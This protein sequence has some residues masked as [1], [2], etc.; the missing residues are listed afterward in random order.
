MRSLVS[1]LAAGAAALAMGCAAAPTNFYLLSPVSGPVAGARNPIVVAVGPVSLPDYLDR[2]QIVIR[3]GANAAVL[4][5][6][7]QWAGPLDDMLP[8]VL[9]EDLASR[10][11][12]DRVVSFPKI[13]NPAFDQRVSVDVSRFDVDETGTAILAA[14]WQVVAPSGKKPILVRESTV[15]ATATSSAYA[16]RVA[17]LSQTLGLLADDIAQGLVSL[18]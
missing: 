2:P 17:A 3:D 11:P 8:R 5:A 6:Y 7:D 14:S 9:V 1:T 15:R 12:E 13:D 10:L 16:D 18:R 4:A